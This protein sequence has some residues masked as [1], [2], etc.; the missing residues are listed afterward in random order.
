MQRIIYASVFFIRPNNNQNNTTNRTTQQRMATIVFSKAT[1]EARTFGINVKVDITNVPANSFVYIGIFYEYGWYPERFIS[2][3]ASN[4]GI[5]YVAP[6][7]LT[8]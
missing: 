2:K 5:T 8:I 7:S 4:N 3:K 6:V 1:Y